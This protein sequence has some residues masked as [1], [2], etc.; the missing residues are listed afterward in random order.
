MLGSRTHERKRT[1]MK[2]T[3][4]ETLT[5]V[6][7]RALRDEAWAASDTELHGA[8]EHLLEIDRH[9]PGSIRVVL[10]A[11]NNAEAQLE[12]GPV[13]PGIVALSEAEVAGFLT[14]Y[15]WGED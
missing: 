13:G 5:D 9:N 6:Q 8:C 15:N 1:T 7:I 11:I 10:R 14:D 12:P 4:S 3:T 2:K